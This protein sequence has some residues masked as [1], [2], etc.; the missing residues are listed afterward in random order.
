MWIRIIIEYNGVGGYL[1]TFLHSITTDQYFLIEPTNIKGLKATLESVNFEVYEV[2]YLL[3]Q[4]GSGVIKN[5]K[6]AEEFL[7]LVEIYNELEAEIKGVK[8]IES[9]AWIPGLF[10]KF[11]KD[12]ILGRC[13]RVAKKMT[14]SENKRAIEYLFKQN[15]MFYNEQRSDFMKK[16]LNGYFKDKN[17]SIFTVAGYFIDKGYPLSMFQTIKLCYIAY[18]YISALKN[19]KLFEEGFVAYKYG[20]SNSE[21]YDSLKKIHKNS[22][23]YRDMENVHD[24]FIMLPFEI[25]KHDKYEFKKM[26]KDYTDILDFIHTRYA[27]LDGMTLSELTH[28]KGTP[29]EQYF[30]DGEINKIPFKSIKN[31]FKKFL[32]VD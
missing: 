28:Q 30:K 14:I 3:P 15:D 20:P 29:W 16:M 32:T 26:K 17:V 4:S 1:G 7:E 22:I 21:L 18:G 6:E 9:N 13:D 27:K 24:A 11:E 2:S 8:N 5:N 23:L 31:Y 19:D 25:E 12:K 10:K